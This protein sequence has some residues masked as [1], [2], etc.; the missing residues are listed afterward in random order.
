LEQLCKKHGVQWIN[1][2]SFDVEGTNLRI[3][4]CTL[5]SHILSEQQTHPDM[6]GASDFKSI[7]NDGKPITFDAYN[8]IHRDHKEWLKLQIEIA[9]GDNKKL[10]VMTHHK[11]TL[12]Q[13]KVPSGAI[14]HQSSHTWSMFETD[15]DDLMVDPVVTWLYGHTHTTEEHASLKVNHVMVQSNQVGYFV[16]AEPDYIKNN[17]YFN[18]Q[19]KWTYSP[20]C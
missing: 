2:K 20:D 1:K 10:L 18:A 19:W 3:I 4:G 14:N 13:G 5:W 9:K 16:R 6:K 15:C 11:P 8:A 7:T 17:V 12:K